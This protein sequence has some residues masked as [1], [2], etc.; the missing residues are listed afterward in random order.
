MSRRTSSGY[1]LI[2][3]LLVIALLA[4]VIAG[5]LAL[6]GPARES[7][8]MREFLG[9][10]EASVQRIRDA[11]VP[12]ENYAPPGAVLTTT[13]SITAGLIP[14]SRHNSAISLRDPWGRPFTVNRHPMTATQDANTQFAFQLTRPP[15]AVCIPFAI[16]LLQ[17]TPAVFQ[18]TSP[19]VVDVASSVS[20]PT[21]NLVSGM[22]QSACVA[23]TEAGSGTWLVV[24]D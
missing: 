21:A 9:D 10:L 23:N 17:L 11:Y 16:G 8:R 14:E 22:A 13:Y 1:S 15:D 24:F 7:T 5:A 20:R 2:E 3:V 19:S 6:A 4:V 12:F 18:Q